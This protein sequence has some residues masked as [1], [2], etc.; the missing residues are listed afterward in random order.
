MEWRQMKRN[1][2]KEL[3]INWT[4]EEFAWKRTFIYAERFEG[5]LFSLFLKVPPWVSGT[6]LQ[7]LNVV[8]PLLDYFGDILLKLDRIQSFLQIIITNMFGDYCW[9]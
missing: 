4:W 8:S 7:D 6:K 5:R 9:H 2:G 1:L 3:D